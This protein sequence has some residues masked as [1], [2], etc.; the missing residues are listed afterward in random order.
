NPLPGQRVLFDLS[1]AD[2]T[3]HVEATT[4]ASGIASTGLTLDM[5][6][7][8]FRLTA[9]YPGTANV[10]NS[11]GTAQP[12]A[13]TKEDSAISAYTNGSGS[14]KTITARLTQADDATS[15]IAGVIVSFYADGSHVGDGTTDGSGTVSF[16]A[17]AGAR[18]KKSTYE[19][20]FVGNDYY[21]PS[22]TQA[23]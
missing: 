2:A 11:S 19:V 6:P 9:S 23:T 5:H 3:R 15:G 1:S 13:I 12:F 8:D 10:Y 21:S 18:G 4:D 16:D 22:G 20:R 17:P 14:K 7:G